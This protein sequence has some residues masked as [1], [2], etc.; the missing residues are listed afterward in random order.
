MHREPLITPGHAIVC[1]TFRG[2]TT[3]TIERPL[4]GGLERCGAAEERL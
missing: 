3:V 2:N 4:S 1:A